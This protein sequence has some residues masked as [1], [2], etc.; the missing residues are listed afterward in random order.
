MLCRD[1]ERTEKRTSMIYETLGKIINYSTE[2]ISWKLIQLNRPMR[3]E[4]RKKSITGNS[5][6]SINIHDGIFS[7]QRSLPIS[8]PELGELKLRIKWYRRKNLERVLSDSFIW[9]TWFSICLYH[10]RFYWRSLALRPKGIFW[11]KFLYRWSFRLSELIFWYWRE[12]SETWKY[13]GIDFRSIE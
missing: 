9:I 10:F 12:I 5:H 6:M 13:L 3:I 8:G 7:N 1:I 2:F 4:I 11:Y